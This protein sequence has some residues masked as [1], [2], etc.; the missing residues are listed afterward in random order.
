ME[1]YSMTLAK[2]R[3]ELFVCAGTSPYAY[4][5]DRRF[6]RQIEAEWGVPPQSRQLS[7]C[8]RKFTIPECSG[9]NKHITAC[10]ISDDARDLLVSWSDGPVALFDV[11]GEPDDVLEKDEEIQKDRASVH[12]RKR[13]SRDSDHTHTHKRTANMSE[14]IQSQ[15]EAEPSRSDQIDDNHS[16]H[17]AQQE[18]DFE[19]SDPEIEEEDLQQT[20]SESNSDV[21]SEGAAG[22]EDEDDPEEETAEESDVMS[23]EEEED[24][25]ID[26]DP[27]PT[28]F[29]RRQRDPCPNVPGSSRAVQ[30][31]HGHCNSRTVKDVNF[32][33]GFDKVASGS[34]DG[35][36]FI[37]DKKTAEL[38]NILK[39][40]DEVVRCLN[41]LLSTHQINLLN[42]FSFRSTSYKPIHICP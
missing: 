13:S 5:H 18:E 10:K 39:G 4:L 2:H 11:F 7:Q 16:S 9:D 35:H 34:D 1:L 23:E 36:L 32:V 3:P 25:E 17:S 19:L 42:N 20:R 26:Y 22:E 30:L 37:W 24:S 31:Y 38:L 40:D 14:S 8:V 33:L 27:L 15:K 29:S 6:G 12:K 41:F 28:R 21:V